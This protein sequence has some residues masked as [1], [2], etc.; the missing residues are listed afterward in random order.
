MIKIYAESFNLKKKREKNFLQPICILPVTRNITS[1]IQ[2][3]KTY[4]TETAL[5]T[6]VRKFESG[7][8]QPFIFFVARSH[9]LAQ[10]GL[11]LRIHLPQ[12]PN[13][14]ITGMCGDCGPL[15][16]ARVSVSNTN[17]LSILGKN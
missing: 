13:A 8:L 10:G 11:Y 17:C 2:H 4:R 9:Y 1:L 3:C 6:Y 15:Y 7:N 16:K 12:P 14:R 5:I